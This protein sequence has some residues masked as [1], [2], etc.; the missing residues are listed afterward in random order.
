MA[1]TT[2]N[3]ITL[4]IGVVFDKAALD[5][6]ASK[7][8]KEMDT[9]YSKE[10]DKQT[11]AMK[12]QS[13][14][15][16]NTTNEVKKQKTLL[17]EFTSGWN[18]TIANFAK[19][20]VMTGI[21]MAV[22]VSMKQM[23]D[24]IFELDT[25]MTNLSIV[26]NA[27]ASELAM[28]DKRATE[29]TTTL[30]ALK[31]EVI[32]SITE[33]ARAGYDLSDA[34]LLA[35]KA[36]MAANVGFTELDKITTF[37]IA[38]LKSFKLEAEGATRM[39]DV[40]FR[41]ANVTAIDLEG[42]GEA[43]LRSANTL[44]V[45]GATL[46]ESAA[47]IAAANESI[48]DPA[49]VGTALKTI[50]SR[51]RG[52]SEEGEVVPTLAEDFRRVGVEIQNADGSFR[53]IY[54][55][56]EEFSVVYK[57]LD[58]LTKESLL[59]K[60]A[61][62]R[63]K[64]IMI[65]LLENFDIAQMALE[66]AMNS[67]GA[68]AQA[69]E[70]YLDS[71]EGKTKI[72]TETW[73]E[74]LRQIG[75]SDGMK[76]AIDL[77]TNLIK[78]VTF[79]T[80]GIPALA[81]AFVGLSYSLTALSTGLALGTGGLSL[82]IPAL[83]G[84]IGLISG[85]NGVNALFG[86]A[87]E[88]TSD[89]NAKVL[90]LSS[91][92]KSLENK[93]S[94]LKAIKDRT[95]AEDELLKVLQRKLEIERELSDATN[96][97]L[98][99]SILKDTEKSTAAINYTLQQLEQLDV[100]SIFSATQDT[101][102]KTSKKLQD[103]ENQLLA[104]QQATL[105][106]LSSTVKGSEANDNARKSYELLEQS[107]AR[108]NELQ[109]KFG[110]QLR[111]TTDEVN[112]G[113]SA[114][115]KIREQFAFT[116]SVLAKSIGSHKE[117]A[118]AVAFFTEKGYLTEEM[119]KSLKDNGYGQLIVA[120]GQ[121]DEAFI[122]SANVVLSSNKTLI[123][124]E[125]TK[126]QAIIDAT[127]IRIKAY[128]DEAKA[129]NNR[130]GLIGALGLPELNKA[131]Q[132]LDNIN[133]QDTANL[134][135]A[136]SL[137]GRLKSRLEEIGQVEKETSSIKSNSTSVTEKQDKS[138]TELERTLRD[139]NQEI[140]LQQKLYART[141]DVEEQIRINEVLIGLYK[142]QKVA[143]ENVR[144]E[145]IEKNKNLKQGTAEYDNYIDQLYKF[146]LQVE[147]ATNNIFSLT[148]SNISLA[149]S[150]DEVKKKASEADLK[151][152]TSEITNF[153]KDQIKNIKNLKEIRDKYYDSAIEKAQQD[154]DN[155]KKTNDEI[156]DQIKLQQ[157]LLDLQTL[158]E[159]RQNI[160]DNKNVR[161]VRDSEVG[162]EW[163]ADPRELRKAEEDIANAEQSIAEFRRS[164]SE[165]AELERLEAVKS[166]IEQERKL[167]FDGYDQRIKD[168]ELFDSALSDA[169]SSG[170]EITNELLKG[171]MSKYGEIEQTSYNER[172]S[173]LDGFISTYNAKLA[174]INRLAADISAREQ[175]IKNIVPTP[176]SVLGTGVSG[177]SGKVQSTAPSTG[178][179][180]KKVTPISTQSTSN[181]TNINNLNINSGRDSVD[182]II[183]DA[184]AQAKIMKY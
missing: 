180:A 4:R 101:L 24:L 144:A 91:N 64:N 169:I 176:N 18:K 50:A 123:S 48:Q 43:F 42:I 175:T 78:V 52:I 66:E 120:L 96:L 32:N 154:I 27:S 86:V 9:K 104:D 161:L 125:I 178:S 37:L 71:L 172:L 53:N 60:L 88:T 72:L 89:L 129:R 21:L 131:N 5:A 20:S 140:A 181:Q 138:L 23:K 81:T 115:Q 149:N 28:V 19:F 113:I 147:D 36:T 114:Q 2:T 62:K 156:S 13:G 63:Q 107:L 10:I 67:A 74:F 130:D 98:S 41:V 51:L 132:F 160:I 162:F 99:N 90:E 69:N 142:D 166:A 173:S 15:I 165:K 141:D 57:T 11:A 33:F 182:A 31:G 59:E 128:Q 163:V 82:I 73:G 134:S 49:K 102:D 146:S 174:E 170:A 12:K 61:G 39:M 22:T 126:T 167:E 14:A 55:V 116:E 164:M 76:L 157:M 155:F 26:T 47:L 153:V 122:D 45:A 84:I 148:K 137:L 127:R 119:L 111:D 133:Q 152:L 121:S 30:G 94:D 105:D 93:I 183:K 106:L 54:D 34:M 100:E 79:L 143:I 179:I 80:T 108:V 75:D 151:D 139:V 65:G 56:F 44:E 16:S 184:N 58:D 35:E 136:E 29:L 158:R 7:I 25:A 92:I 38:G 117:L 109:I 159:R 46:E 145:F 110:F 124:S 97:K 95:D 40:L 17:G 118:E 135:N 112:T 3:R 87:T 103:Y 70:K 83:A 168:W 85:A 6:Q 8:S 68:V 77:L 171:I 150:L 177:T 1:N